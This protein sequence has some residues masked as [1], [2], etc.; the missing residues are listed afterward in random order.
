MTAFGNL[1]A[2]GAWPVPGG[3]QRQAA[4]FVDAVTVARAE[5]GRI[6]K[7]AIDRAGRKGGGRSS[8]PPRSTTGEK[9]PAVP[10]MYPPDGKPVPDG[11]I[12][13]PFRSR[14]S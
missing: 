6:Q 2:Y 13:R 7:E 11:P 3:V 9:L 10:P 14:G 12:S 5:A 8:G 4:I 1:E